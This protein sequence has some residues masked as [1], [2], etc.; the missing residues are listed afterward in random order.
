MTELDLMRMTLIV[1]VAI[2]GLIYQRTR[3]VSGGMMTGA[4][5]ALL[6]SAGS[7][8]DV[9]GWAVLTVVSFGAIRLLSYL[10]ALPKV[11]LLTTAIIVSAAVHATA[12]IISGGKGGSD[13]VFLG[14]FEV[15]LAGGMYLTPGLTAYDLMRQGWLRTVAALVAITGLTFAVTMAVASIG[16][17]N[18]PTLPLTAPVS[19]VYTD[20]SFPIVMLVCI[21]A[22]EAMRLSFG[23]GSGGIIGAVF[24]VE[25]L[26]W[27]SF[28]V[29][30]VLTAI[31]VVITNLM[32]RFFA[33]TPR[34]WFQFTFI[35]GAMVAWIGLTV[36]TS[37]GIAEV[38][39][40]AAYALE[41][42]LAVGLISTDV[43]RYG[44][45]KTIY[46]KALVLVAVFAT[47]V[48]VIQGGVD[49]VRFLAIE[50]IILVVFYI[51][52]GFK[53]AR[54]WDHARHVG[55]MNPILPGTENMPTF[56]DSERGRKRKAARLRQ[57]E[58]QKK[59][60]FQI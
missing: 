43:A 3:I 33:L 51:I 39:Q 24:F 18:A 15:V 44:T 1:G 14:A 25:L 56:S 21:I 20:L 10:L 26:S 55:E 36:G 34:Q 48:F 32:K 45:L 2:A 7:F 60:D 23:W 13:H 49:A 9:I 27:S 5:L 31:T 50:G 30:I 35:L 37:L 17:L 54:G 52:G 29:I 58:R 19:L 46:G 59:L 8:G 53:A 41:P 42:L 4:Y 47:N 38:A 22:A 28:V 40:P 57:L 6:I 12:V 11:W 16:A